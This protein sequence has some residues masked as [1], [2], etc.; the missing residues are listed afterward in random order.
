MRRLV[1]LL[2]LATALACG[3]DSSTS[4]SDTVSGTYTLRTV[5]GV[6]LPFTVIQ[7]DT[8]KYE[9][10][11][12]SFT[13]TENGTWT[14]SGTDRTTD[15]GQVATGAV[16]DSGTYVRNG[17]TITL[18]STNGSVDGTIGGGKLTLSNDAVVA[19]YQK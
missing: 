16:A 3:G 4:P 19:V 1:T 8:F 14:E 7:L 6:P 12:D 10:T 9:I 11:S 18:I 5:N 13:L 17:T 15:N 2:V